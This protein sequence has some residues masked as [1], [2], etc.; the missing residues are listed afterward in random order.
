MIYLLTAIML[1][2]GDSSTGHIYKQTIHK[3]T[4]ITINMEGCGPCP[5]FASFAVAFALQLRK[6]RN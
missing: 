6:K 2:H 1:S 5:V 4:Q 3:T